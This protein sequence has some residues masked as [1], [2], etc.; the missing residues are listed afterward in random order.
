MLVNFGFTPEGVRVC[1]YTGFFLIC[2]FVTPPNHLL[3]Q[4]IRRQRVSDITNDQPT[5]SLHHTSWWV[6]NDWR[7]L[8]RTQ[9]YYVS[10]DYSSTKCAL[11]RV[12]YGTF[13]P[14]TP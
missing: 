4:F 5:V 9:K 13:L 12:I 8:V 10:L 3:Y 7:L 11:R 1:I 2:I 14:W 6:W